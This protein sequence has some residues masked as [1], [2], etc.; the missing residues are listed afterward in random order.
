MAA[1]V[2]A[3]SVQY[4][5]VSREVIESRLASYVTRND[6]REPAIRTIFEDAGCRPDNLSEQMVK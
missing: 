1:T 2:F 5:P 4:S 3:D 6:K